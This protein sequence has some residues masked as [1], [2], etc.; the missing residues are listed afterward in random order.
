VR[1]TRMKCAHD[2]V[3]VRAVLVT[4]RFRTPLALALRRARM[5]PARPQEPGGECSI[6]PTSLAKVRTG[7]PGK[8]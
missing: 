2:D 7:T 8:S 3:C 5:M 1:L 4:G 6:G